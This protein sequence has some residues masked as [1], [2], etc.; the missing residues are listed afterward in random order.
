MNDSFATFHHAVSAF[1]DHVGDTHLLPLLIALSLHTLSLAVRARVWR[2]IMRSAFPGRRVGTADS[3]WAYMAGI[4]ANAIAPFRG[5]DVVR[6]YAARRMLP[7]ASVATIVSTLLAETLFGLVVIGGLATW[8]VTSGA[9]PPIVSLPDAKAFEFSFYAGHPVL[10]VVAALLL[11][12]LALGLLRLAEHRVRSLSRHIADGFRVLN[13]PRAF[14]HIVALPQLAD[15]VLRAATAYAMLAAFGVHPTIQAALLV[16][17][18]DSVA[19]AIPITPGGAGTQQALLAFALAGAAS[20]SQ[21]LAYSVG[22]QAVITIA[23][24]ALGLV[25]MFRLFGSVNV[26]QLHR[27]AGSAS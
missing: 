7:G 17:V 15:W 19:T 23:N 2:N 16:L 3:F 21:I 18:I 12:V 13:P 1:L 8:A 9:L 24:I 11:V 26:R 27:A 5:G 4:G 14:V 20:Q 25:A 6:V 10:V 22:Q